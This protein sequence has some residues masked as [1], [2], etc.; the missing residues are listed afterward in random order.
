VGGDR[1]GFLARTGAYDAHSFDAVDIEIQRP[2]G[3]KAVLG[4]QVE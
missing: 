1:F 2:G 4:L 3:Q